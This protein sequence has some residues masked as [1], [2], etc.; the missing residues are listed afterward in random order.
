MYGG[1]NESTAFV[2]YGGTGFIINL[3]VTMKIPRF[4]ISAFELELSWKNAVRWLEDPLEI[5]GRSSVYRFG[6]R[7]LPEFERDQVLN[8]FADVRR[9]H[10]RGSSLKGCLLGIDTE[11]I[12]VRFHHGAMI[13]GFVIV[14]DQYGHR[15]RSPIS[16]W[17]DRSQELLPGARS[18][19]TRKR[20]FECP[21]PGFDATRTQAGW[22]SEKGSGVPEVEI[23]QTQRAAA[24]WLK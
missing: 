9:I 14:I 13:P 21:D 12:P 20:L 5:D 19:V 1:V 24:G 7:Y 3:I 11:P 23:R 10:S 4:A 18:K 16:L 15:Y 2:L 8:H 6:G 17:T 22:D